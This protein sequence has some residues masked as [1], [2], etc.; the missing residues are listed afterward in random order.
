MIIK[1]CLLYP[2]NKVKDIII[3]DGLVSAENAGGIE[4]D[5]KNCIV[6]PS[7]SELHIHLDSVFIL[8]SF[9]EN[10]SGTLEEGIDL[11]VNIR[12]T[13]STAKK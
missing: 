10:K 9:I 3:S 1:N 13:I 7:F 11:W 4:I 12:R 2:E 6:L 5:A 8:N